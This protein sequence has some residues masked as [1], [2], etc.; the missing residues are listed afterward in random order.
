MYLYLNH[1][2]GS[3]DWV[4]SAA[5]PNKAGAAGAGHRVV[6]GCPP[7]I[8][9]ASVPPGAP[10]GA[11]AAPDQLPFLSKSRGHG[12]AMP[13]TAHTQDFNANYGKGPRRV[14]SLHA[15]CLHR[16]VASSL[17]AVVPTRPPYWRLPRGCAGG[18]C[19][20]R[21]RQSAVADASRSTVAEAGL[22]KQRVRVS[23]GPCADMVLSGQEPGEPHDGCMGSYRILKLRQRQQQSV[24]RFDGNPVW[25]LDSAAAAI[26]CAGVGSDAR[27]LMRTGIASNHG[28]T[29]PVSA[30][31]VA[32]YFERQWGMWITGIANITVGGGARLVKLDPAAVLFDA[33]SG[34]RTPDGVPAGSWFASGGT[35]AATVPVPHL[36]ITCGPPPTPVPT[37]APQSSTTEP[38]PLSIDTSEK[39]RVRA[40]ADAHSNAHSDARSGARKHPHLHTRAQEVRAPPAVAAIVA[41]ILAAAGVVLW[42]MRSSRC[43][44][45][46]S[47]ATRGARVHKQTKSGGE[48]LDIGDTLDNIGLEN[49]V[50]NN[51]HEREVELGHGQS[52]N[53]DAHAIE[54][55][56]VES[57]DMRRTT[58]V[59]RPPS[60]GSTVEHRPL[61]NVRSSSSSSLQPQHVAV[62]RSE[63]VTTFD[64]DDDSI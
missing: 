23:S 13:D 35:G 12:W 44:S 3:V 19:T 6:L 26:R 16:G 34:S 40:A 50:L 53:S 41:M 5:C 37:Q 51:A 17:N 22:H 7:F 52:T 46:T 10:P 49:L 56:G 43:L 1:R 57:S 20:R 42:R 55:A 21:R 39:R 33:V 31:V 8:L 24:L 61:L 58:N 29:R 14:P 28:N 60:H 48:Y 47:G 9:A 62:L 64:D 27:S 38:P 15:V 63:F 36:R 54:M 11:W 25:V 2:Y 30:V 18:G 59:D 32:L 45:V 4:V